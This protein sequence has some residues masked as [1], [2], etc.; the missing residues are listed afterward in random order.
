MKKLAGILILGV[1][2][3]MFGCS[4]KNIAASEVPQVVRDAF[5]KKYPDVQKAEWEMEK[6][7][8]KT[9]Y[10]VEF[11]RNGK[12]VEAVFSDTGEFIEEDED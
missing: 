10:E 1:G 9:V 11:E 12:E 6:H 3:I 5:A 7:K 2:L 4:E 8:G